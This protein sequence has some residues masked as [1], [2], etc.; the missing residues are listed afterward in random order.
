MGREQTQIQLPVETSDIFDL[1]ERV[2]KSNPNTV[3][4][5]AINSK[6]KLDYL[7]A[8]EKLI[9]NK[10]QVVRLLRY[11]RFGNVKYYLIKTEKNGMV[12][13]K[14]VVSEY[15]EKIEKIRRPITQTP[16]MKMLLTNMVQLETFKTGENKP[17]AE[18][19]FNELI[20]FN[21]YKENKRL[22]IAQQNILR[23][24]LGLELIVVEEEKEGLD[25]E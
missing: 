16:G 18:Q 11:D 19:L 14:R 23:K 17:F 3:F 15:G 21:A 20:L 7:S 1:C 5:W 13:D 10:Q 2:G 8:V 25:V 22:S 24:S 9:L 4:R 12:R 6:R